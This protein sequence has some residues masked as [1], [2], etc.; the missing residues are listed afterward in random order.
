MIDFTERLIDGFRPCPYSDVC[1]CVFLFCRYYSWTR[2]IFSKRR[3]S[4]PGVICGIT[5]PS[6]EVRDRSMITHESCLL[7]LK[8]S[9]LFPSAARKVIFVCSCPLLKFR[10]DKRF[11]LLLFPNAFFF[12]FR[13]VLWFSLFHSFV[14]SLSFVCLFPFVLSFVWS[15]FHSHFFRHHNHF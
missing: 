7:S 1:K 5:F 6:S 15:F 2:S 13:F 8:E 4:T 14:S 10:I 3:F 12:F 11:Y 9:V